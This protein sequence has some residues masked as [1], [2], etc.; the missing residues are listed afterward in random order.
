MSVSSLVTRSFFGGITGLVTHGLESGNVAAADYIIYAAYNGPMPNGPRPWYKGGHSAEEHDAE[1]DRLTSE[2][3]EAET[4]K[5]ETE[6]RL[7]EAKI[8]DKQQ[9]AIALAALGMKHQA[10]IGRLLKE[11]AGLIRRL[12]DEEESLIILYS[13]PFVH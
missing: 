5:A 7:I 13:L 8:K 11:R 9:E 1:I 3:S 6:Q 4:Q 2:I 12:N 10:E